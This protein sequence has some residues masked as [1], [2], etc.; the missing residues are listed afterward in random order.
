M[1]I[2]ICNK[3]DFKKKTLTTI[4]LN[5]YIQKKRFQTNMYEKK[6]L[7]FLIDKVVIFWLFLLL[8][9]NVASN[10]II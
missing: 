4:K 10:Q 6:E 2:I 5:F 1:T 7:E 9:F 8:L 3:I